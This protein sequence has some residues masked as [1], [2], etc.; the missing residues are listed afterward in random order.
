MTAKIVI[1]LVCLVIS[2]FQNSNKSMKNKTVAGLNN[3]VLKL[4]NKRW[5]LGQNWLTLYRLVSGEPW[6][7]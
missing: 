5:E 7:K 4:G 2:V 6:T 3:G 1:G